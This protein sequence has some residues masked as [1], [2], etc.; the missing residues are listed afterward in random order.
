[1]AD[2]AEEQLE[3]AQRFRRARRPVQAKPSFT[4]VPIAP[5]RLAEK[6]AIGDLFRWRHSARYRARR[7]NDLTHLLEAA[8]RGE[9]AAAE[10]L[11][12]LVYAELRKLAAANACSQSTKPLSASGAWMAAQPN[13]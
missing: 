12:A 4:L 2:G 7:M 9:S 8:Q 6:P 5:A 13:C 10:Q 11:L 1:M 3:A